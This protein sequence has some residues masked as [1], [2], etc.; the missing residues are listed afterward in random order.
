LS[1]VEG[2]GNALIADYAFFDAAGYQT[3]TYGNG[4]VNR[5]DYDAIGRTTRISSAVADYR[6]GYDPAGNRLYM[7]RAHEP[8]QPADVY[9]RD[10]L[11]Q[12]TQVWYGADS[13]D[14]DSI[15]SQDV[16]ESFALDGA[17]NRLERQ[18]G[19]ASQSYLPNDGSQLSNAMNR[20][21]SV[22]GVA[23]AYDA[24]GNTLDDGTHTYTY[25]RL[26]RLASVSGP[27]GEATYTYD[28]LGRRLASTV[29]GNK[30]IFIYDYQGQVLEERSA[31]NQLLA[32]Y[33]YGAA[34]DEPLSFER[35]G[36]TYMYH[37]DALGSV[38][39]VSNAAGALVE[40]YTYEVYGAVSIF[41]AN[42][43]ALVESAVGNPYLFNSRRFDPESGNYYYRARHYSP[44]LGRFLQMDPAGLSD[45]TNLYRYVKNQPEL[46]NDPSGMFAVKAGMSVKV[47]LAAGPLPWPGTWWQLRLFTEAKFFK[48]CN[49]QTKRTEVWADTKIG[50]SL[51]IV[52]GKT[53]GKKLAKIPPDND[54]FKR[55]RGSSSSG[56]SMFD[57]VKPC[58]PSSC[59]GFAEGF[60]EG[61]GGVGVG[62]KISLKFPVYP[63]LIAPSM[64]EVSAVSG[65]MGLEISAG[66]RGGGKCVGK[67]GNIF[68]LF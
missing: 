54:K 26:N 19:G 68:D 42:G 29:D 67:V 20:Y 16:Q 22:D 64:P 53:I 46:L 48:C 66:I 35:Q 37:R 9:D 36:T 17:G 10:G 4:L 11:Y 12:L 6:Y 51:E 58:P 38:T 25:D 32:A 39:E 8:N 30:T 33:T 47:V 28:A 13:T 57:Q 65:V 31:V 45:G 49:Q 52:F 2:D 7:Q 56:A 5:L 61:K 44:S 23:L 55:G 59:S 43:S 18:L 41:A 15:T 50:L 34:L 62:I 27:G 1:R 60:I 63:E 21:E 3:L 24:R 14:K 40:R